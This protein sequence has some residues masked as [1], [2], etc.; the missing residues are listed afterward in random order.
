MILVI[1]EKPSL[2][3]NIAAAIGD[4]QKRRGYLEGQGLT[5]ACWK[6]CKQRFVL[7]GCID[8]IFLQGLVIILTETWISEILA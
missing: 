5:A 4:M 8:C 3:R 7:H 2:A 6:Y 1:A